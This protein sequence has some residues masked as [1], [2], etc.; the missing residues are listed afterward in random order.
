MECLTALLEYIDIFKCLGGPLGCYIIITIIITC[1]ISQ[2]FDHVLTKESK[3]RDY[4]L[5]AVIAYY[6]KHYSTFCYHGNHKEWVYLDDANVRKVSVP[7]QSNPS[8]VCHV[9]SGG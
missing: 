4:H 1:V 9:M 6:G 7:Q 3:N 8:V 2:L 5:T